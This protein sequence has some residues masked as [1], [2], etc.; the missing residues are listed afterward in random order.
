VWC[1]DQY[2]R[3][4]V[5][6][7]DEDEAE[8]EHHSGCRIWRARERGSGGA[9]ERGTGEAGKRAGTR[10]D[11]PARPDIILI[12]LIVRNVSLHARRFRRGVFGAGLPLPR[13]GR[14]AASKWS[15]I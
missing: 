3:S 1:E 12:R 13:L 14:R 4:L 6:E 5:G 2:L 8:A 7:E 9:G 11:T 10:R 15:H